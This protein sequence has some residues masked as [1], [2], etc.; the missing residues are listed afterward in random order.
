[1]DQV[2]GQAENVAA[3]L[4]LA[5]EHSV[6]G[7]SVLGFLVDISAPL[8]DA[9]W[10]RHLDETIKLGIVDIFLRDWFWR[11]WTIRE[12]ALAKKMTITCG[13]QHISWNFDHG[14]LSQMLFR[15]KSSALSPEWQSSHATQ[16]RSLDW[17]PFPNILEMQ[18]RTVALEKKIVIEKNLLDIAFDFQHRHSTDPRDKYYAIFGLADKSEGR[19]FFIQPDYSLSL[20]SVHNQFI[21]EIARLHGILGGPHQSTG[22]AGPFA[23]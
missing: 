21:T 11:I 9:P 18:L 2:Y 1:M 6:V 20:E 22:A 15:I 8:E 19:R 12:A 23:A 7:M 3:F 17:S 14:T 4:G 5:S 16:L 10:L 13:S